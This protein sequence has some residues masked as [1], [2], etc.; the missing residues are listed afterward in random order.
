MNI[1]IVGAGIG[2]T[3]LI[4][5]FSEFSQVNIVSVIDRDFQ[6]PGIIRARDLGIHCAADISEIDSQADMIIEATGNATVQE[7]LHQQFA[8][9][10][11]IVESDV[12]RLLMTIVDQKT[13]MTE[14]LNF[15]LQEIHSN[16][17]KL[18]DE[19]N[20]IVAVTED[21]NIINSTL[22]KASEESK[23]FIKNTDEMIRAVN[24]ITQQNKILGL[25]ASIEAARAGEHGRGFSVVADEVQKMS[26][27]TSDFAE[28]ISEL[29]NALMIENEN[30]AN[31]V[32]KLNDISTV[33]G[34]ITQVAKG[35]AEDLQKL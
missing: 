30:I 12:A 33:Q 21:L 28:Q 32:A 3:K 11:R 35:I 17:I 15:Q 4:D 1:A 29:L 7:L 8:G 14:R 20:R 6:A 18:H 25:N 24:K 10:K 31:E 5:L 34:Q 9:K 22:V 19:M 2:G 27:I 23:R 13:E 26:N 16:S